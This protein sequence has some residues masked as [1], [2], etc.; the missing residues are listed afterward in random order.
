MNAQWLAAA[1]E[2]DHLPYRPCVLRLLRGELV[3][4]LGVAGDEV[5][6]FADAGTQVLVLGVELRDA[7]VELEDLGVVA[8]DVGGALLESRASGRGGG[9]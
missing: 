2:R 4:D 9:G 6:E 5:V 3:D 7:L 1:A 8:V